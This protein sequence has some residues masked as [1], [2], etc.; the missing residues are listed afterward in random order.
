MTQYI[1]EFREQAI[2]LSDEVVRIEVVPCLCPLFLKQTD[3]FVPKGT[4]GKKTG[5]DL[6]FL[7][8]DFRNCV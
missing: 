1:K 3:L 2:L 6:D 4:R 8:A 7:L 5:T